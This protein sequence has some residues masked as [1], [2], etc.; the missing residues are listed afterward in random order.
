[1]WLSAIYTLKERCGVGSIYQQIG[2]GASK[3][4]EAAP[5]PSA[6]AQIRS[7]PATCRS[8]FFSQVFVLDSSI[9][10][11]GATGF[12]GG[13][14]LHDLIALKKYDITALIRDK[15]RADRLSSATGVKTVIADLDS[16]G[17]ADIV[18][19]FDIVL[20]LAHADHVEGANAI[21]SGLEKRAANNPS[22][23]PLLIHTSGTGVLIDVNE[24]KGKIKSEKIYSDGD[25]SSYHSLPSTNIHKNVDDIVLAA[26]RRGKIDAIIVAPP[27]IWGTGQGQFNTHSIQVPLYIKAVLQIGEGI[28][29]EDGINTWS[30]IHVADLSLGYLTILDA[31]LHGKIPSDPEGRYFFC[32]QGEYEQIQ[33]AKTVTKALYEKG[34]VKKPEP[35]R[36]TK[37]E[38]NEFGE[39]RKNVVNLTGGNSRSRAVLLRRLGWEAERG[40]NK[41][42]IESIKDEVEYVL[43]NQA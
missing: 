28:V 22:R 16:A 33:V 4:Q 18:S 42:F 30:I 8:K 12:I 14:V 6:V 37:A 40:G 13:Q 26:G 21:V 23:K 36:V 25:L 24:E 20:H 41:E 34:K 7:L 9:D 11:L 29:L 3:V 15:P 43:K 5:P 17:L 31:A 1:M 27:T 10:I 39:G 35:R 2:G 19:Q 38:V 32:E